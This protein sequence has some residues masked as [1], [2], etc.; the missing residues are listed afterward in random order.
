MTDLVPSAAPESDS[1][2]TW[3]AVGV[4][5][6]GASYLTIALA[7]S[8]SLRYSVW[9]EDGTIHLQDRL[10]RG[11]RSVLHAYGGYLHL[12]PRLIVLAW[13]SSKFGRWPAYFVASS[14]VV[15]AVIA[16]IVFASCAQLLHTAR[17]G[18]RTRLVVAALAGASVVF[19]PPASVESIGNIANLQFPLLGALGVLLAARWASTRAVLAASIFVLAVT[20]S[21]PLAAFLLPAALL[22][23]RDEHRASVGEWSLVSRPAAVG[24]AMIGGGEI[25]QEL[26]FLLQSR[27]HHVPAIG[28]GFVASARYAA[29]FFSPSSVPVGVVE[30]LV[31]LCLVLTL[32]RLA[33]RWRR[34]SAGEQAAAYLFVS[35]ACLYVGS[36]ALAG[37]MTP[38]YLIG[39][40][41]LVVT[42]LCVLGGTRPIGGTGLAWWASTI[43]VGLVS[44]TSAWSRFVPDSYRRS[45]AN[46]G[47]EI[48]DAAVV[49][50]GGESV[51]SLG[52]GPTIL[53]TQDWGVVRVPCDIVRRAHP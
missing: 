27:V 18:H 47:A 40:T 2:R 4:I 30:G 6:V 35:A 29:S 11:T 23:A 52:V 42:G 45:G 36:Y 1:P 22:R 20:L 43:V 44:A 5:G 28:T 41:V 8:W 26:A 50:A 21:T 7:R 13:P 34:R 32:V 49:C 51:A 53:G 31:V 38:R 48:T 39:P 16:T 9:A 3:S 19:C 17:I 12:I 46:W 10:D 37:A 14:A 15:W 24:V 33:S 25:V